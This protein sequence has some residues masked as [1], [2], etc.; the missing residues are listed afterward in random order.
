VNSIASISAFG[1]PANGTNTTG[2][3]NK[4]LPSVYAQPMPIRPA[5]RLVSAVGAR[6]PY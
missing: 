4:A 3:V 6:R 1:P 5:I 2:A